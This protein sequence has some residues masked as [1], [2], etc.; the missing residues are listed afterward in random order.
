[1]SMTTRCCAPAPARPRRSPRCAQIAKAK[2]KLKAFDKHLRTIELTYGHRETPKYL[3]V[4]MNGAL[5]R[6]ALEIGA[7]FVAQG[8]LDAPDD[9]FELS[10]AQVTQGAKGQIA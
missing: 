5:H 1:M 7:E 2:G 6:V 10:I 3:V 4:M 8:R 9:I